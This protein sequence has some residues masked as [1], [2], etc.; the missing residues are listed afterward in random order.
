MVLEEF[1]SPVSFT[2]LK[3]FM[4]LWGE[5]MKKEDK[6]M[7]EREI[8]EFTNRLMT[9]AF[10]KRMLLVLPNK[11]KGITLTAMKQFLNVMANTL[12]FVGC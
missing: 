4:I 5:Y 12:F 6:K 2:L 11:G 10:I 9:S 3:L 7:G 8:I 1:Y